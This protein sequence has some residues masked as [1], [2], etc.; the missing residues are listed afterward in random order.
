MS[1]INHLV[2]GG[3]ESAKVTPQCGES[4][5]TAGRLSA[6]G[7]GLHVGQHGG[8]QAAAVGVTGGGVFRGGG[9]PTPPAGEYEGRRI[10]LLFLSYNRFYI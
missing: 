6:N 2:S 4:V 9:E 8:H 5:N 7:G 1:D 10:L 3:H